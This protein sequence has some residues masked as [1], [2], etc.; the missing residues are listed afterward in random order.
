MTENP[1]DWRNDPRIAIRP[2]DG[3]AIWLNAEGDVVIAQQ[4]PFD[5]NDEVI[6]FPA[7]QAARVTS[8]ITQLISGVRQ[9]GGTNE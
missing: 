5:E 6:T 4:N 3:I 2:C 1:F 9:I 7:E 8:R